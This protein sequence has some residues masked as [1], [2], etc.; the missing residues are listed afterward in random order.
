[1]RE[2][3]PRLARETVWWRDRDFQPSPNV[4]STSF[5]AARDTWRPPPDVT[6]RGTSLGLAQGRARESEARTGRAFFDNRK[7]GCLVVDP[8]AMRRRGKV[9]KKGNRTPISLKA[10]MT[11]EM[12]RSAPTRRVFPSTVIG[13]KLRPEPFPGEGLDVLCMS[14]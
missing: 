8:R 12:D 11:A 7:R 4:A 9:K 1:M 3:R 6:P 5:L 2:A 10:E 13:V 14:M